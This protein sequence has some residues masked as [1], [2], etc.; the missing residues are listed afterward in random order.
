MI[1]MVYEVVGVIRLANEVW[2]IIRIAYGQGQVIRISYISKTYG[3]LLG[4][5]MANGRSLGKLI[6]RDIIEFSN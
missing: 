5:L 1:R 3:G 4:I 2:E 6:F